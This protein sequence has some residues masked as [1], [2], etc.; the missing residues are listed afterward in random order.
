MHEMLTYP[1][2]LGEWYLEGL[3][4]YTHR[5]AIVVEEPGHVA[6][7]FAER[8]SESSRR[9]SGDV[10][11]PAECRA[12]PCEELNPQRSASDSPA[13]SVNLRPSDPPGGPLRILG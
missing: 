2:A 1:R 13:A 6:E 5:H 4:R 8:P 11:R 3:L 7:P 9:L 12:T 10:W